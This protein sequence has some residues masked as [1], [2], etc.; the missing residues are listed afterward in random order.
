MRI[1][2]HWKIFFT[3]TLVIAISDILFIWI[4]YRASKA[5]LA[6]NCD[7]TDAKIH[8]SFQLALTN[9]EIRMMQLATFA[10]E[11]EQLQQLFLKGKKAITE[12]GN[13]RGERRV[14]PSAT[15]STP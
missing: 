3:L 8:S 7:Q 6:Y 10:A 15:P 2:T 9:T 11:D 1:T 5:E 13:D 4:N 12:E 14:P